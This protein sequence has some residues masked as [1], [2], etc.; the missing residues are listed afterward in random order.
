MALDDFGAIFDCELVALNSILESLGSQLETQAIA[1]SALAAKVEG[2][3]IFIVVVDA[4][5][6]AGARRHAGADLGDDELENPVLEG[7]LG[8]WEGPGRRPTVEITEAS[9]APDPFDRLAWDGLALVIEARGRDEADQSEHA[10]RC[11]LRW[12]HLFNYRDLYAWDYPCHSRNRV[13]K[14]LLGFALGQQI[15]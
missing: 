10:R 1:R 9:P 2:Q 3:P 6:S 8:L 4:I 11:E 7:L 12:N 15:N 14:V 13:M 5:D